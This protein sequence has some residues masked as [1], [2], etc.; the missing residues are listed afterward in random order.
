MNLHRNSCVLLFAKS[1]IKGQ[2]KTRL[3]AQLGHDTATRLYENFVLD[4]LT[5]LNGLNVPF[6][7]CLDP[8][9]A[10]EQFKRWLGKEYSYAPQ[11]GQDLGQRMRNAFSQAFNEGFNSVVIIGSDS[12]DLPAEYLDLAFMVLGMNNVVVGP[13]SDGGYYLI[14]FSRK[15]FLPEAF[16]NILWSTDSVFEQTVRILKRHG[17][18]VYRLPLWYDVDTI[19]DLKSLLLR[20]RNTAFE[21]SRTYLYL[22]ADGLWSKPDVRL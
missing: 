14:G 17:R 19:S 10:E 21:K 15:S 9:H 11:I 4:V 12:P 18:N 3:A 8:P 6:R 16:N 1:P 7:I 13:S 2:V 5:L 20:N 22:T